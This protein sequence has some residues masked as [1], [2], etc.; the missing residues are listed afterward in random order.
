MDKA[1]FSGFLA[2]LLWSA[3]TLIFVFC[4]GF[5]AYLLA[6]LSSLVSFLI[7]FLWD[8]LKGKNPI[9]FFDIPLKVIIFTTIA[10]GGYRIIYFIALKIIPPLEASLINYLWPIFIVFFSTFLPG[11]RAAWYH[12]LGLLCGFLGLYVLLSGKGDINI[13]WQQG[14]LLAFIAALIWGLYSVFT[15][16]I[17]KGQKNAV[18]MAFL[19]SGI[20]FYFLHTQIEAGVSV[21]WS[22]WP[23]MIALGVIS[24]LGY[25]LWDAGMKHGNV[26]LLSVSAYFIP[27]ISTVLLVA[28]DKGEGSP[29]VWIAALLIFAGPV[30]ASK[31]K[32]LSLLKP[33]KGVIE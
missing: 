2:I 10:M 16:V 4:E 24:G 9:D 14:H 17:N 32:V 22:D 20:F 13:T 33:R 6:S 28:F 30:I 15:K 11:S 25:Y 23:W 18:P 8:I 26:K 29:D 31:D 5:P 21:D 12:Y 1:T 19:I 7:F 27:L 3:S